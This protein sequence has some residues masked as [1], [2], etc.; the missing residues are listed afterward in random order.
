MDPAI[1]IMAGNPKR[2][3]TVQ[4]RSE[5]P[6]PQATKKTGASPAADVSCRARLAS[7]AECLRWSVHRKM[8]A[9]DVG[10]NAACVN[11][12]L[13]ISDFVLEDIGQARFRP[14]DAK[15]ACGRR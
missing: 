10:Q 8:D 5:E 11:T 13:T 6:L 12:Y 14:N 15:N 7:W 2:F 3:N 9:P 4:L 1:F